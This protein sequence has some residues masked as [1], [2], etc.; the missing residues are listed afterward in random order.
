MDIRRS[1]AREATTM[2]RQVGARGRRVDLNLMVAFDAIYR[3]RNLT[4]AGEGLGLSQ[5]AMSHALS[6]LRW[7]F[8]DP[9]FL[10]LPRGLQ[11]TAVADEVAPFITQGIATIRQ[12]FERKAFDPATS[13][14]LFT[15]AMSDIGEVAHLPPLLAA[16]SDAP[17]IRLRTVEMAPAEARAALVDGRVDVALAVNLRSAAPFRDALIV[18]HGYATVARVGHPVIRSRLTAG[19]FRKAR[20]LLVMPTGPVTHGEVIERALRGIDAEI[21]VQ[22]AHFHPV[23]A[24]VSRSD[25]IATV[26]RG[27]AETMP[28]DRIRVFQPPIPLPRVRISLYWHERYDKDAGNAWLRD[29]YVRTTRPIYRTPA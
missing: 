28:P 13:T 1:A 29:L 12:G 2:K 16:L 14:R 20:H 23:A 18:E 24:I 10:R 15:I 9:L 22:V 27:L 3:T 17:G 25:L 11:P 19:Q 6:R 4:A 26:P 8:D 7:T 5:P 21:A